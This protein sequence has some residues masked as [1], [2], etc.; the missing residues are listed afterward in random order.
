QF[1]SLRADAHK[2][3]VL[4]IL[5]GQEDAIAPDDRGRSGLAG[6]RELPD[7]VLGIA[8]FGGKVGFLANAVIGGAA[9]LRPV[10]GEYGGAKE[11]SN[12][13]GGGKAFHGGTS[14]GWRRGR[15]PAP[16]AMLVGASCQLAHSEQGKLATCPHGLNFTLL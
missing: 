7:D 1:F 12:E 5:A 13:E 16:S 11:R 14:S 3:Q 4:A 10:V 9:P 8:P 15:R 6:H 2:H